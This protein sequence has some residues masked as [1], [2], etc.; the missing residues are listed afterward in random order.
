M[1]SETMR[2]FLSTV[3]ETNRFVCPLCGPS[4]KNKTD[5]TLSVTVDNEGVLWNCHHCGDS[6]KH[7]HKT[8]EN[9]G[10][11]KVSPPVAISVPKVSNVSLLEQYLSSR[12]ID[13]N[14]ISDRF[15]IVSGERHFRSKG[16][17]KAGSFDAVGFVY[18]E[19]E[20]V[21]WRSIEGKRFTQD[22]AARQLW[23]VDKLMQR[24]EPP[25]VLVLTEGEID[26]CSV[27]SVVGPAVGVLSVPNGAP[28][29]VS[30]NKVVAEEDVKFSYLFDAKDLLQAAD[31]IVIA[32]DDDVAGAALKE[33]VAR[34]CGRAKCREI[35]YPDNAKD[36]NE[37]L[38]KH[39]PE[40]LAE[41]IDNAAHMPLEGVYQAREYFDSVKEL[42]DKG[43][44]SGCSTGISVLDDFYTISPGQLSIVTGTPG[45]GK[46]EFIDQIMVN[47]AKN[48]R[49]KCA[50]ASFENPVDLHIAKISE[51]LVKKP[52]FENETKLRMTDKEREDAM[53]F[54]DQHFMF[55]E[56]KSGDS[57]TIDSILDR[58]QQSILR[59][60]VRFAVIDP[61]NYIVRSGDK[62]EHEHQFINKMLTRLV[63]FA[64]TH[65][66]HICLVA[67]P[68][69]MQTDSQGK[70]AVPTGHN[71]SG[72]HAFFSK[73]DFGVTVQREKDGPVVHVWK[74]RFKWLGKLGS[75]PLRYDV[76]T[77]IFGDHK[78]DFED[79][80]LF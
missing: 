73:A 4:R 5:R 10:K 14:K 33:E 36:C 24:D 17:D 75:V 15:K 57:V 51:K 63:S 28:S 58:L 38:M 66:V 76:S 60:G 65:D 71:I 61:Y 49:W 41:I 48:Y 35:T 53:D 6:G 70:T 39:G 68:A 7:T 79:E 37:V 16:D 42:Y 47:L 59:L 64:R 55:I 56:Q 23:G 8:L 78:Y 27:A 72:S 77:G 31:S 25:K 67:H 13:Y 32:S 2:S 54:V 9:E 30:R 50:V 80:I 52:F 20:A 18:G 3:K 74:C 40:A 19:N 26:A 21:K 11:P 44:I 34:R 12:G 69:K 29:K 45:S 46:S 43:L 22:G 1:S 62:D